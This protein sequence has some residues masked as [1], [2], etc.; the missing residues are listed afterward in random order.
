MR[1]SKDFS[2]SEWHQLTQTVYEKT[3]CRFKNQDLLKQAFVRSSYSARYGGENNEK[4]EFFGDGILAFYVGKAM[5]DRFGYTK[6]NCNESFDGDCE[7]AFRGNVNMFT[8]LKKETVSN[9]TLA[10]IIDDWGISKYLIVGPS[11]INAK[12]DEEEKVKAD[13]FEALLGAIAIQFKWNSDVLEKTV[14]KMLSLEERFAKLEKFEVRPK[15][16]DLDNAVNTLKELS[17]KG[18]CNPPEYVFGSPEHLGYDENGDPRWVCTCSVSEWGITRQVWSNSKKASK[19]CAAYLVL[20]ERFEQTDQYGTSNKLI[21]WE[22][23]NG[24]LKPTS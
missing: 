8:E 17:E 2:M 16:F 1:T 3:G 9:K 5:A 4:L 20:C 24:E 18:E 14:W 15:K 23:R 21:I 13:L 22:Y 19:K 10:E 12:A 7:Y 6:T 11:D